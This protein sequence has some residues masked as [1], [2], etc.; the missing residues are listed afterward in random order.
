MKKAVLKKLT[1]FTKHKCWGL[2]LIT[3]QAF[4]KDNPPQVFSCEYCQTF[5]NTYFTEHL[6]RAASAA[7]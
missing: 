7:F 2:F 1:I 5:K 6:R 3:L 4:L